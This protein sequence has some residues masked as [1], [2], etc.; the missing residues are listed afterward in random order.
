MVPC[1]CQQDDQVVLD[2]CVDDSYDVAAGAICGGNCD[3]GFYPD[4]LDG[5]YRMSKL[6]NNSNK[7]TVL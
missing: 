3:P 2:G 1:G 6:Q 7:P 4:P 5:L